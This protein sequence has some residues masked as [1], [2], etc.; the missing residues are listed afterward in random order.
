MIVALPR[1]PFHFYNALLSCKSA[2][3]TLLFVNKTITFSKQMI[4][5]SLWL[6]YSTSSPIKFGMVLGT[7]P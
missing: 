2:S 1:E 6:T 5:I 4:C 7:F 3:N